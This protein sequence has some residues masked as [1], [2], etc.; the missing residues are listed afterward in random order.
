MKDEEPAVSVGFYTDFF[1]HHQ[2]G[3]DGALLL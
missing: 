2:A 1:V 3:L